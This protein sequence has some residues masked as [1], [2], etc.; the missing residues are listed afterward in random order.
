M[1]FLKPYFDIDNTYVLKKLKYILI[2]FLHKVNKKYKN[3]NINKN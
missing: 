2:P 1:N 3:K